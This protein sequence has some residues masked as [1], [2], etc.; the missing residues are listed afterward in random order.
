[1]LVFGKPNPKVCEPFSSSNSGPMSFGA[2]KPDYKRYLAGSLEV[3]PDLWKH[4]IFDILEA[5]WSDLQSGGVTSNQERYLSSHFNDVPAFWRYR[6][7]NITIDGFNFLCRGS[8][9]DSSHDES[10]RDYMS[11]A[12]IPECH[13]F[14]LKSMWTGGEFVPQMTKL[15]QIAI[16]KYSINDMLLVRSKLALPPRKVSLMPR[17]KGQKKSGKRMSSMQRD[18]APFRDAPKEPDTTDKENLENIPIL[19]KSNDCFSIC[20]DNAG[21]RLDTNIVLQ[22]DVF[23]ERSIHS[24]FTNIFIPQERVLQERNY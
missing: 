19:E 1:M 10:V 23:Q 9:V 24:C 3:I 5:C 18:K 11:D 8:N 13:G 21:G 16:K 14:D 17:C 20:C 12:E 2:L 15:D 4:V 7:Q 6:L 22:K